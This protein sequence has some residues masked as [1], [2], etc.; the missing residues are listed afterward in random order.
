M[1]IDN[2]I[3]GETYTDRKRGGG[4]RIK[5]ALCGS[6]NAFFSFRPAL[7]HPHHILG[8]ESHSAIWISHVQSQ[9]VITRIRGIWN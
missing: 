6:V 8:L 4:W 5:K 7:G 1:W 2:L 9:Q 3:L